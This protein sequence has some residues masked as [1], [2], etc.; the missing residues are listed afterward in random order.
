VV[1]IFKESL[2]VNTLT[3]NHKKYVHK[4]KHLNQNI[5]K[6]IQVTLFLIFIAGVPLGIE[7]VINSSYI[8]SMFIIV[9]GYPFVYILYRCNC[10]VM[11]CKNLP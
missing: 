10:S 2:K 11:N 3:H 7:Y 4:S 6:F 8:T 1:S 5:I 9:V